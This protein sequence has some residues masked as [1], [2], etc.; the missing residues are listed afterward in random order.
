MHAAPFLA[1]FAPV[2]GPEILSAKPLI[3]NSFGSEQHTPKFRVYFIWKERS[4]A[5]TLAFAAQW[6]FRA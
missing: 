3:P 5:K 6:R 4:R 2:D 1:Q